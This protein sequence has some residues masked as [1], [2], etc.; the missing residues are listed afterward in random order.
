LF[1]SR[2][3]SP[4]AVHLALDLLIALWPIWA[5]VGGIFVARAGYQIYQLRRLSRSGI[6]EIDRM[7]GPEFERY[8]GTMFRR[9]GYRVDLVGSARGDFGCDL[10]LR[11]DGR[12][13]V[14]QAKRWQKNVGVKAVQEAVAAKAMY[15]CTDA[16]VATNS[17]FTE[18]ARKLARANKVRLYDREELIRTL[19]AARKTEGAAPAESGRALSHQHPPAST[20]AKA[21]SEPVAFCAR[22]GRSVSQKVREYCL[23]HAERFSGLIYCY[24]HQRDL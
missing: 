23:S 11:K 6:Q 7:P 12:R 5:L 9:L 22:C 3:E 10:L 13:I 8:L 19:L 4:S 16:A 1:E 24:E 20:T 17:Y 21:G 2:A 18:Q 15:D 14:V